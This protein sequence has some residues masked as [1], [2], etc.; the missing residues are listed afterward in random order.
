MNELLAKITNLG[1]EV[2]GILL[3]GVITILF[4][5]GT[6]AALGPLVPIWTLGGMPQLTLVSGQ[7]IVESVSLSTGVGMAI[8]LLIASYFQGHM[9]MW[10]GR[11]GPMLEEKHSIFFRSLIFRIPKPRNNFDPK[12]QPLFDAVQK[13]FARN[14]DSLIWRQFFPL[15]KCF[16]AQNLVYSLVSTYQTKYTLH[17][18][19]A[20]A[21][22]AW[23]WLNLLAILF[24]GIAAIATG[25]T[26]HL[27]WLS[28]FICLALVLVYG[29]ANSYTYNWEMFANCIITE[30]YTLLFAPKVKTPKADEK[31]A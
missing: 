14:S 3:P 21:A 1:Y 27:G 28:V 31:A 2:F 12:L 26:P 25:I 5:I 19:L 9:L 15:G 10:I 24:G 17:R 16:L 20:T 22:A 18:S 13:E 23:F 4:F 8:P 7:K 30:S 6:W 29:F 11:S